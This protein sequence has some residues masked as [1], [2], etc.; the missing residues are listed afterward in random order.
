MSHVYYLC[1]IMLKGLAITYK[2]YSRVLRNL[3][4]RA[5]SYVIVPL[6]AG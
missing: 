6:V 3:P 5:D 2:F 4:H 1:T